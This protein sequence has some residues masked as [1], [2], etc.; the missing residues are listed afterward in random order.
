MASKE[1]AP[2]AA[3]TRRGVKGTPENVLEGVWPERP[4]GLSRAG[5]LSFLLA[6]TTSAAERLSGGH[7]SPLCDHRDSL[8]SHWHP[9][10]NYSHSLH[11]KAGLAN[12]CMGAAWAGE[13]GR[14]KT[15]PELVSWGLVS[16]GS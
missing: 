3:G 8:P 5:P 10:G 14:G 1:A 6:R 2:G 7:L 11:E 16:Q 15:S 12:Y 4:R 13:F 9:P